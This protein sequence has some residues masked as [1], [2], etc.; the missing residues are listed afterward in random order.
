[1]FDLGA[2]PLLG[3]AGVPMLLANSRRAVETAAT[4]ARSWPAPTPE[5]AKADFGPSLP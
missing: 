3:S 4:E 2:A 1:M 5:S